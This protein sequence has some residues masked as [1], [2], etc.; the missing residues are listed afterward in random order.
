MGR[1]MQSRD[2]IQLILQTVLIAKKNVVDV[3]YLISKF[4]I[5]LGTVVR[6]KI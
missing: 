3:F 5:N 1:K 6:S 4:A 2:S